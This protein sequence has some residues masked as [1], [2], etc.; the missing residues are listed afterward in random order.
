MPLGILPRDGFA[1]VSVSHGC[2][3]GWVENFD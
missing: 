1:A 3:P 2:D